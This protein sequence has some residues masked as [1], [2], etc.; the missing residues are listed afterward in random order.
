VDGVARTLIA[1]ALALLLVAFVI[2]LF[3]GLLLVVEDVVIG[4]DVPAAVGRTALLR[5]LPLPFLL[6][7]LLP[8]L[9]FPV[10]VLLLAVLQRLLLPVLVAL[11]A[12]LLVHR[13][14][15]FLLALPRVLLGV[16]FFGLVLLVYVEL[17]V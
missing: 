4:V 10:L 15:L 8:I 13:L 7:L 12:V 2:G 9:F 16:D 14:L 5:L 11:L 17:R 1:V 3:G 6:L